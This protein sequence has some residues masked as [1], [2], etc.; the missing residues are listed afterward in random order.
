MTEVRLV[1]FK[2]FQRILTENEGR[3]IYEEGK[4]KFI[5]EWL[6]GS[7]LYRTIVTF[8]Q[9]H[10]SH[11]NGE[12]DGID[13]FRRL[14][15]QDCHEVVS[16]IDDSEVIPLILTSQPLREGS[17]ND[18]ETIELVTEHGKKKLVGT[19]ADGSKGILR[20]LDGRFNKKKSP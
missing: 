13:V 9:I 4:N 17:I 18:F 8:D 6:G 5:L 15:L 12:G 11:I 7:F 10:K 19:R 14:Y 1:S 3:P 20:V 2:E 16:V